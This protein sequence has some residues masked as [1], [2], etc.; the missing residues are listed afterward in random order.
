[1][2]MGDKPNPWAPMVALYRLGVA[3][4]GYVKTDDGPQ[5]CVYVPEVQS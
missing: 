5:F 2:W 1:M 4:I 3:P